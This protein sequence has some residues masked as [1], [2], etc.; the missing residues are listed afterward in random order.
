[1]T[2]ASNGNAVRQNDWKIRWATTGAVVF[3][4]AGFVVVIP[5]IWAVAHDS[6]GFSVGNYSS[7]GSYLQGTT[8]SLFSLGGLLLIYATFR[9]QQLQISQQEHDQK[10]QAAQFAA[11][12]DSINRQNFE[13]SFFQLLGLHREIVSELC[14]IGLTRP[15]SSFTP[16]TREFHGKEC[17][18]V[19]RQALRERYTS[20]EMKKFLSGFLGKEIPQKEILDSTIQVY[21]SLPAEHHQQ[22]HH[23]FRNLYHVIKFVKDSP[24]ENKRRYTSL[25]RAQLSSLELVLLFYNCLSPIGKGFKPLIEE[26]GLLEHLDPSLLLDESHKSFYAETA[27][28]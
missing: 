20:P 2:G 26:F 5:M 13:N 22:L 6:S 19:F 3:I 17:F 1:M 9:A 11:Q 8:A 16:E 21:E 10:N 25:V 23:Y 14:I 24:V 28:K 27:Y 15:T 12:Q 7:L 4:L 18:Q